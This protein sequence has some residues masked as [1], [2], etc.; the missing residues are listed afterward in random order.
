MRDVYGIYKKPAFKNH[1]ESYLSIVNV[2]KQ[3]KIENHC[4]KRTMI[5]IPS[6]YAYEELSKYVET[7]VLDETITQ[8]GRKVVLFIKALPELFA[9][10]INGAP[11]ELVIRNP[12]IEEYSITLYIKDIE[13][14][15][16]F[17]TKTLRNTTEDIFD[18]INNTAFKLFDYTEIII[19]L[20]DEQMQN[21][22]G[23]S[24]SLVFEK[25]D[26]IE[27]LSSTKFHPKKNDYFPE[28]IKLGYVIKINYQITDDIEFMNIR[29][30]SNW[31]QKD[32]YSIGT[33]K[34][35]KHF[36][37]SNYQGLGKQ[38]Y[39]QEQSLKEFLGDIFTPNFH[40]YYSLP[41]P[42]NNQEEL[43]DFLIYSDY[44]ILLVESKCLRP[45]VNDSN[46]IKN[47]NSSENSIASLIKKA[48]TQLN[49]AEEDLIKSPCDF[50]L[51]SLVE[52]LIYT[53][54]IIKICV[55]SDI[56]LINVDKLESKLSSF[57][58]ETLPLI[59]GLGD[60]YS[61]FLEFGSNKGVQVFKNMKD[62]FIDNKEIKFPIFKFE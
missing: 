46:S 52:Q 45:F 23:F 49:R 26:F 9:S 62:K 44:T 29:K 18:G 30:I 38:G 33:N 56:S 28:N 19:S 57:P 58:R 31:Q 32:F 17:F 40:L 41:R 37:P 20:L 50:E 55:V 10:I 1:N 36:I 16:Y 21:K 3:S 11:L 48:T 39:L 43:T 2:T 35:E 22:F 4:N 61:V 24:A 42:K 27:W 51:G 6:K 54:T 25:V 7:F 47:V 53:E 5:T 60:F 14:T 59:I 12:K 8:D 15:P 13:D 34:S